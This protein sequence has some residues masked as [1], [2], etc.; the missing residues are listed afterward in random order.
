MGN[1]KQVKQILEHINHVIKVRFNCGFQYEVKKENR[2]NQLIKVYDTDQE[3][4][5]Y[6]ESAKTSELLPI[7][8]VIDTVLTEI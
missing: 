8:M 7:L 1:D 4:E 5:V 3:S 2:S 6:I